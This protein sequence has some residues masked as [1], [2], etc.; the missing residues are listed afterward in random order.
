MS[1]L[2]QFHGLLMEEI[3]GVSTLW[4]REIVVFVVG[5]EWVWMVGW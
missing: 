3:S 5:K 1:L 4:R 2:S